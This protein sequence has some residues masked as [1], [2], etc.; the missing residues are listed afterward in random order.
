MRSEETV[1]NKAIRN[2]ERLLQ[3][4]G[5]ME[6]DRVDIGTVDTLLVSSSL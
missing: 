4:N 6:K 1:Y 3:K 2:L 5:M